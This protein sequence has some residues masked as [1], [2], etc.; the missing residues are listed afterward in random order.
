[1]VY[2]SRISWKPLFYNCVRSNEIIICVFYASDTFCPRGLCMFETVSAFCH[3]APTV[4]FPHNKTIHSVVFSRKPNFF[5]NTAMIFSYTNGML[6]LCLISGSAY[7]IPGSGTNSLSVQN[8]DVSLSSHVEGRWAD[9]SHCGLSESHS[10]HSGSQ[11]ELWQPQD[12]G[13]RSGS[14]HMLL[15]AKWHPTLLERH[16]VRGHLHQYNLPDPTPWPLERSV[17]LMYFGHWDASNSCMCH[18]YTMTVDRDKGSDTFLNVC[19]ARVWLAQ[20]NPFFDA[21]GEEAGS[22]LYCWEMDGS[23]T[24]RG[25]LLAPR[26]SYQLRLNLSFWLL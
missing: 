14:G 3:A 13:F 1:M 8:A 12:F 6:P 26:Q 18:I 23:R 15:G 4:Y 5:F 10:E 11:E 22:P 20:A 19:E 24:C 25:L 9:C 21:S 16:G 7:A 17:T 2:C